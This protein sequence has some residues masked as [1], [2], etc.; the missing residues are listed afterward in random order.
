MMPVIDAINTRLA[1]LA[2]GRRVRYL[3]IN[4]KL[5]DAAG[6][7]YDGMANPDQLHLAVK[8][9]QVWADALGSPVGAGAES[10]DAGG[11][12]HSVNTGLSASAHT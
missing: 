9:Y 2:D 11:P 8:G 4:H 12:S 6:K 1:K 3:D 5:A 10:T 7:L